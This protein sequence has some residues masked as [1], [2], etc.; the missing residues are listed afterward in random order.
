VRR[1]EIKAELRVPTLA[2]FM[3]GSA[4][5]ELHVD[6]FEWLGFLHGG[7]HGCICC[8]ARD[9]EFPTSVASP[10]VR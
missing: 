8:S 2:E 1:E 7:F 10:Q 6:L 9:D 4:A 5:S 3:Q